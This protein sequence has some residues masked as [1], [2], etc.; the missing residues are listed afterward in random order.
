MCANFSS[1]LVSAPFLVSSSSSVQSEFL[2]QKKTSKIDVDQKEKNIE[3]NT[4]WQWAMVKNCISF[5][6]NAITVFAE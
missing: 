1:H 3:I 5:Q 6:N 2:E 4:T